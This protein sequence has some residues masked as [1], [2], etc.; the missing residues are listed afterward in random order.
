MLRYRASQLQT[1]FPIVFLVFFPFPTDRP[2]IKKTHL[3]INEKKGGDGLS[4]IRL[5]NNPVMN[6]TNYL[7]L[8]CVPIGNQ[9]EKKPQ[10]LDE[11]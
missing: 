6:A 3:T 4:V 9:Q 1:P 2:K 5:P 11:L 7:A 8:A 10:D